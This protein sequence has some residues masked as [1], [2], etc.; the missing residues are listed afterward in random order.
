MKLHCIQA[1]E[2]LLLK[3]ASSVGCKG[4]VALRGVTNS[5]KPENQ[6]TRTKQFT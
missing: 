6:Y 1:Y 2:C 3:P 4:A 5:N